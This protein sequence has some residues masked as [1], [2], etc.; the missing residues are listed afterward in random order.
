MQHLVFRRV[1]NP[2]VTIG[3]NTHALQSADLASEG[4]VG[5]ASDRATLEI[6]YAN[7]PIET[8]DERHAS[9][10]ADD[11]VSRA[12]PW[13]ALGKQRRWGMAAVCGFPRG[14]AGETGLAAEIA[15]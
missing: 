2:H 14:R 12:F 13:P 11:A 8:G 4:E 3:S 10:P 1:C 9:A 7:R 6:H 5:L 15:L